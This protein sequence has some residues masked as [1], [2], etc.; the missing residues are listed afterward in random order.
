MKKFLAG[1]LVGAALMFSGQ[2]L[3]ESKIGKAVEAEITVLFDGT[4]LSTT[5]IIIE[6]VSYLPLRAIGTVMGL[7]VDYV[8]GKVILSSPPPRDEE[9]DNDV[10]GEEPK[11]MSPEDVRKEMR[12]YEIEKEIAKLE[13]A[14]QNGR[15]FIEDQRNQGTLRKE[16]ED[17]M[18]GII[19]KQEAQ[20]AELRAELSDLESSNE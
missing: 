4:E 3:A 8:D 9:G 2:V 15:K 13:E 19:T 1:L 7:G 11:Y 12:K 10:T 18:L 14:I 17:V 20:L 16:A 6:G 5:G